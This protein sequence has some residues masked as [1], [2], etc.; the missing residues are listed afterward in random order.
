MSYGRTEDARR[1]DDRKPLAGA[2]SDLSLTGHMNNGHEDRSP[3][4]SGAKDGHHTTHMA[5]DEDAD[6]THMD[7]A[8]TVQTSFSYTSPIKRGG[9][10]Q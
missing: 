4:N 3:P 5:P 8:V 9:Y 6:Y 10:D 7:T 2:N 1:I